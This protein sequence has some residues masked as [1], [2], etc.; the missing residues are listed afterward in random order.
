MSDE[1]PP[2][3]P[4]GEERR[5]SA[6][7]GVVYGF[8]AVAWEQ[9]WDWCG[10]ET[11]GA[12]MKDHAAAHAAGIKVGRLLAVLLILLLFAAC[13]GFLISSCRRND[14]AET[15]QQS[16]QTNRNLSTSLSAD[17]TRLARENEDLKRDRDKLDLK[18]TVVESRA[19]L[20][21]QTNAEPDRR[22]DLILER[23]QQLS[24]NFD[25]AMDKLRAETGRKPL[26]E[27]IVAALN[28][29]DPI[30]IR[31]AEKFLSKAGGEPIGTT[32]QVH[33]SQV[34]V[35]KSLLS[36]EGA[37]DFFRVDFL[38]QATY[39]LSN[40]GSMPGTYVGLRI[41]IHPSL[42][43]AATNAETIKK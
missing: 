31:S 28:N 33:D 14:A 27:R 19:N 26:R 8:L 4:P 13:G 40:D 30:I 10:L 24:S 39:S 20:P 11:V 1:V 41:L 3:K 7:R 42:L 23:V 36:E 12:Q 37:T 35:L 22:L 6:S 32:L 16:W 43:G 2:Q 9:F 29:I 21:V 38:P 15:W 17:N 18:L 5:S 34:V 25:S